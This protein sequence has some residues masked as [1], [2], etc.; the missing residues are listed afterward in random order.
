MRIRLRTPPRQGLTLVELLVVAALDI[1]ILWILAYAFAVGSDMFTGMKAIGDL[2]TKLRTATTTLK[3]DL[4]AFHFEGNR[5]VS[6]AGYWDLGPPREG[7]FRIWQGSPSVFEGTDAEGIGSWRATDHA[8][9]FTIRRTGN[10]PTDFLWTRAPRKS[11]LLASDPIARPFDPPT[12]AVYR[13]AAGRYTSQWAEVAY[14]LRRA[15]ESAAGPLYALYRRQLLVVPNTAALNWPGAVAATDAADYFGVSSRPNPNAPGTL[16]FNDPMDLTI[17]QRRFGMHPRRDGGI[18]TAPAATYPILA[19]T[20][21]AVGGS[22]VVLTDVLSFDIRVRVRGG[23]EF[24]DLS[25][26]GPGD[27]PVFAGGPARVF[28]SWSQRSD[29]KYDYAGWNLPGT[30]QS[31]PLRLTPEAVQISIRLWHP[32]TQRTRQVTIVQDL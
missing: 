4:S 2:D 22:D 10:R 7:F 13:D 3:H 15:E 18:P 6:D 21:P 27:N 11:P 19:E 1:F 24:T 14:F 12:D 32:K 30:P 26:F 17:P 28:D 23:A 5:R 31:V 25:A 20:Y 29:E 9:H 8:L 16:Y